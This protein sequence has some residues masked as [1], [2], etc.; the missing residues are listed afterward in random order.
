[1]RNHGTKLV[2]FPFALLGPGNPLALFIKP[3]ILASSSNHTSLAGQRCL[4]IALLAHGHSTV[5][6]ARETSYFAA[7]YTQIRHRQQSGGH[8]YPARL[9]RM[10]ALTEMAEAFG[11][12]AEGPKEGRPA[13]T[14]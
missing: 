12:L 1:M 11:A 9:L 7:R 14:L 13:T 4:F 6:A 10:P 8:T 5:P 2:S 3:T